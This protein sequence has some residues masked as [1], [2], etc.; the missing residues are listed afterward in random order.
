MARVSRRIAI[1]LVI[2]LG[3]K[4]G[5]EDMGKEIGI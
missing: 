4:D 1:C 5:D 2:L 3:Y